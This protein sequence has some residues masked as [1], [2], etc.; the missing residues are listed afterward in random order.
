MARRTKPKQKKAA[1]LPLVAID[2]GSHS[3]RAIA[4][5]RI[6]CDT[7]RILGVES[8]D[9]EQYIEKGVVMQTTKIG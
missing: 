1:E 7:L 8:I 3:I 4:A 6:D 2:A 5:E 9:T